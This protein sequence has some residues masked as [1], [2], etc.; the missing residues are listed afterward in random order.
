[1]KN[2]VVCRKP[3]FAESLLT[4]DATRFLKN[5]A[6]DQGLPHVEAGP[7]DSIAVNLV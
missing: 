4:P 7:F 1:V 6:M 3:F 5:V 2:V